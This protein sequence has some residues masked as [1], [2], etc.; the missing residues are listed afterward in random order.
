MSFFWYKQWLDLRFVC[1]NTSN[2]IFNMNYILI[3]L[4]RQENKE[5]E[6][7]FIVT[8]INSVLKYNYVNKITKNDYHQ[9]RQNSSFFPSQVR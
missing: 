6:T 8:F 3:N 2:V 7:K 5:K 9:K 1:T 4:M